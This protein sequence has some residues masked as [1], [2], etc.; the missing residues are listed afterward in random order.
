M[1]NLFLLYKNWSQ[2]Y[3]SYKALTQFTHWCEFKM[4][5]ELPSVILKTDSMWKDNQSIV[6]QVNAFL[7]PL[8][9]AGISLS[10]LQIDTKSGII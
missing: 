7:Y 3:F 4:K 5:L 6:T 2:N 9:L 1:L 10:S 8:Y